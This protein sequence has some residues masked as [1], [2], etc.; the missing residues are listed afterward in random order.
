V[1]VD[2]PELWRWIWLAGAALGIGGEMLAAGTFLLLPFGVGAGAAAT[3]AFLN[4][5]LVWQWLAFVFVSAAGVAATRPIARRL[6]EGSPVAGI[7]AQR[8]LGEVA[9]VLEEIP[10][11]T[12][13]TG[14]VRIGRQEW[15]AESRD[16]TP[17]PAGSRA[18]VIEVV[19][20]RLVV[21]PTDELPPASPSEHEPPTNE[22]DVP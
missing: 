9:T 13:E 1:A 17:V 7:G 6:E 3:L 14:L 8:W 21:W 16:G 22:S 10:A 2:S 20:T 11:G 4:V 12:H 19:G 15:R 18:K 5:A